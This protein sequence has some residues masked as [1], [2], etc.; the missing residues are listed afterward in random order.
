LNGFY[1]EPVADQVSF[2]DIF[3][4]DFLHD[5][6]LRADAVQLGVRTAPA[7]HGGGLIYGNQFA[8]NRPY[9]L[10]HG[11]PFRSIL[12]S[13]SCLVDTVLGQD[14]GEEAEPRGRLLFAPITEQAAAEGQMSAGRFRL[15]AWRDRLAAGIAELRRCFMVDARDVAGNVDRRVAGLADESSAQLEVRWNAYAA[16]R[17]PEAG[18]RKAEKAAELIDRLS[19]AESDA[20]REEVGKALATAL[21]MS[22]RLEGEY[23]EAAATAFDEG[24]EGL[25]EIND[26]AE[27]LIE[28]AQKS[29]TA[30]SV[31]QRALPGASS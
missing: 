9:V 4:A 13:D 27:A 29:E 31:I 18:T 22:W 23:L 8:S 16:R 14:R 6:F 11:A 25:D 1:V 19:V 30:A 28:M 2:G 12:I 7:K 20:S 24:R 5:I 3:R 26:L 15:P 21:W 10:A 17:G